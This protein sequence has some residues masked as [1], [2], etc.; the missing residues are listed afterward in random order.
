MDGIEVGTPTSWPSQTQI[1]FLLRDALDDLGILLRRQ[2]L[3]QLIDEDDCVLAQMC[4]PGR[5]TISNFGLRHT[6]HIGRVEVARNL[7]PIDQLRAGS[8]R[9][10]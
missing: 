9:S 2:L 10:I 1:H 8:C 6:V 3:L 7:E 5:L 4:R